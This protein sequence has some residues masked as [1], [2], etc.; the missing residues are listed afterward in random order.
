MLDMRTTFK[1]FYYHRAM[2]DAQARA[3]PNTENKIS[4]PLSQRALKPNSLQLN[5][6]KRLSGQEN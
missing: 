5:V 4:P 1:N 3:K 2:R 6:K